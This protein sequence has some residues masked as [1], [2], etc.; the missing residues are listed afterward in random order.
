MLKCKKATTFGNTLNYFVSLNKSNTIH[1]CQ[2]D[3]N[4]ICIIHCDEKDEKNYIFNCGQAGECYIECEEKKCGVES[5]INA[6]NSNNLYVNQG[7]DGNDCLKDVL[8]VY[9]PSNGNAT[10]SKSVQTSPRWCP[11]PSERASST[12]TLTS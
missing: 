7:V 9:V 4:D 10:E 12:R 5:I 8:A 3:V 2:G 11:S 1:E 6:T